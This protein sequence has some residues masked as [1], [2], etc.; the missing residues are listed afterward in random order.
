MYILDF[1]KFSATAFRRLFRC[2]LLE[3]DTC[4]GQSRGLLEP[5]DHEPV[6][7]V[8]VAVQEDVITADVQVVRAVADRRAST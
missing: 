2:R 5:A 4:K 8:E 1:L 7:A 6:V 3:G